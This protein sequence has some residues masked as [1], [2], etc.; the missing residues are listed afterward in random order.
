MKRVLITGIS[1]FI[2]N[3]LANHLLDHDWQIFGFDRQ[4]MNASN[5]IYVG[6]ITD[7][8]ALRSAVKECQPEVI[9]HL[10]GVIKSSDSELFYRVNLLGTVALFDTLMDLAARPV[11]VVASSSGVYGSGH[12]RRPISEK[13]MSR[14]VTHYAISKLA[15]E[16]AALRYFTAYHMP[17]MVVRMFNLLGPGQSPDLACSAFARQIALAEASGNE[18]ILTGNL[19]SYRDFLDVRDA[20]RAFKLLVEKGKTGETYNVCS[21][22]AIM[23]GQCLKQMMSMSPRRFKVTVDAGYLQQNDISIQVGNGRK[24]NQATGW[25]PQISL[26]Q[27]LSDLMNYWRQRI[28]TERS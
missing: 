17:V 7:R 2:G 15:Q 27:S 11:V 22:S 21:G 16:H 28:E 3:H 26:N 10:A 18:E 12:G 8:V 25:K 13:Y 6:D 20:V 14:P 5:N 24:L 23:V 19:N 1:G 4:G 9:L